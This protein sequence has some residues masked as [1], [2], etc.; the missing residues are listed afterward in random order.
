MVS[1]PEMV[2]WS[3][4]E[5]CPGCVK[6]RDKLGRMPIGFCGPDCLMRKV[7]DGICF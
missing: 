2:E 3:H 1:K 5:D 6:K 4:K 7:R